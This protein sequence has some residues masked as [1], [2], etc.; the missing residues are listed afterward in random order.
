VPNDK[1]Q[2][3]A[4]SR[5]LRKAGWNPIGSDN[6]RSYDAGLTVRSGSMGLGAT[7]CLSSLN[8][9]Q[10]SEWA[11]SMAEELGSLG[12]V[13]ERSEPESD[14]HGHTVWFR[15]VKKAVKEGVK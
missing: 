9:H 15:R 13:F 10:M 5:S 11:E 8:E 2:A 1:S 7:L 14:E 12:Y 6:P 4:L 3:A